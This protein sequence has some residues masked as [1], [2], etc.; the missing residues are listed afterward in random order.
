MAKVLQPLQLQA[1]LAIGSYKTPPVGACRI[2]KNNPVGKPMLLL[3][4]GFFFAFHTVLVLFNVIGWIPKRT[5]RLNLICLVVTAVSWFVMG[6]WNGIGYCVLTDWHW[7]VRQAL[8]IHDPEG[9]FIEL[10]IVKL[11]GWHAP[12]PFVQ[13]S[14]GIVFVAALVA[15]VI[16]NIRQSRLPRGSA[17]LSTQ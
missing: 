10:L 5:R 9:S 12:A 17:R 2:G 7:Q 14:A 11:T 15:S 8:G 13:I 1:F 3:L 6:A 4:D 16:V